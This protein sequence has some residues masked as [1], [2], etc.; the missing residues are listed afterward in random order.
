MS[1]TPR[2]GI[3]SLAAEQEEEALPA[4]GV[5][6]EEARRLGEAARAY[7]DPARDIEEILT[8]LNEDV[9]TFQNT[10][11]GLRTATE[12][13]GERFA[14]LEA[15]V[16]QLQGQIGQLE[17][18]LPEF[19]QWAQTIEARMQAMAQQIARNLRLAALDAAV[20]SRGPGDPRG[21]VIPM[22]EELLKWLDPGP[23]PAAPREEAEPRPGNS[24]A[25]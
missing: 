23:A 20:R 4:R 2:T 3:G 16:A 17:R 11:D 5:T 9:Q 25:H 14:A 22:A 24:L 15:A 19:Q 7:R 18:M 13:A 1:D 8:G 6:A 12:G 10:M 21:S